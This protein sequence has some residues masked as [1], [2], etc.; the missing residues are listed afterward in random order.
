MLGIPLKFLCALDLPTLHCLCKKERVF[1]RSG[2]TQLCQA[3]GSAHCALCCSVCTAAPLFCPLRWSPSAAPHHCVKQTCNLIQWQFRRLLLRLWDTGA[4]STV[5]TCLHVFP[6]RQWQK[7]RSCCCSIV[8][9]I[10]LCKWCNVQSHAWQTHRIL[11]VHIEDNS[12]RLSHQ[13]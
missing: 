8:I 2:S 13:I 12:Q 9:L 6:S 7:Q 3:D 4:T 1:A 11:R 10:Q 5:C